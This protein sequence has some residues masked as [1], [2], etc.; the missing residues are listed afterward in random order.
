MVL[1][2]QQ[3]VSGAC[4]GDGLTLDGDFGSATFHAVMCFQHQ[5][6]LD[7]DGQVG[8]LTWAALRGFLD[9]ACCSSDPN[10]DYFTT[11]LSNQRVFR[12]WVPSKKW[13]VESGP[14]T[15]PSWLPMTS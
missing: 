11:G 2:V 12:Q 4:G 8:P 3:I 13:Y 1:A 15:D 14:V 9:E 10:W 6:G 5:N 7:N